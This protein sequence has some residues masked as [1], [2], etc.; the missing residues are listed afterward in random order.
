[1]RCGVIMDSVQPFAETFNIEPEF[2][3]NLQRDWDLCM[4]SKFILP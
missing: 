1:M 3:L 4:Q 2:W